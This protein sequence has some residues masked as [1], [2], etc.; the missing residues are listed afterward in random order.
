MRRAGT[1]VVLYEVL[2]LGS[3]ILAVRARVMVDPGARRVFRLLRSRQVRGSCRLFR[4]LRR[5]CFGFRRLECLHW[6]DEPSLVFGVWE[7][8]T[9]LG[10]EAMVF[11]NQ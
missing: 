2:H 8:V 4:R 5:L 7:L 10:D 9:I 3:M 1:L 11:G 6:L